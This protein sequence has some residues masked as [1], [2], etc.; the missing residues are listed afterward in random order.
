VQRNRTALQAR[1]ESAKANFEIKAIEDLLP[2]KQAIRQKAVSVKESSAGHWEQTRKDIEERIA[3]FEKSLKRARPKSNGAPHTVHILSDSY[4]GF[5]NHAQILSP[6]I[7][8]TAFDIGYKWSWFRGPA[9]S[10][11]AT[12]I[13]ILP[14]LTDCGAV[15]SSL[16]STQTGPDRTEKSA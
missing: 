9:R 6:S 12:S 2:K 3:D 7:C 10:R 14:R 5:S 15:Q 11:L 1:G 16:L 13:H 8:W 4:L